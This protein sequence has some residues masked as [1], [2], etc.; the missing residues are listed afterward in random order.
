MPDYELDGLR[1]R[2]NVSGGTLT[3]PLPA[4]F[5][6]A[7]CVAS[8]V[9]GQTVIAGTAAPTGLSVLCTWPADAL[10]SGMWQIQ[11]RAGASE[12]TARTVYDEAVRVGDSL[13]VA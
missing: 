9:A 5:A 13:R 2:V 6:W 4:S 11:V 7:S 8:R 1:I 10:A 3:D 12:A